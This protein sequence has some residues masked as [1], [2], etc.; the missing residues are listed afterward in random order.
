MCEDVMALME[1]I[2]RELEAEGFGDED[3]E[4]EEYEDEDFDEIEDL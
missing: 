4:E 2:E 1:E 3:L